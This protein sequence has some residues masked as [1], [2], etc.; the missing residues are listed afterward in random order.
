LKV[1]RRLALIGSATA[2]VF[3]LL[4]ATGAWAAHNLSGTYVRVCVNQPSTSAY[5]GVE[6]ALVGLGSDNP[7]N[8]LVAGRARVSNSLNCHKTGH[9]RALRVQITKVALMDTGRVLA[10]GGPTGSAASVTRDTN[11]IRK[12]CFLAYRV[13]VRFAVRYTDGALA[14]GWANSTFWRFPC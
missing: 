3:A 6:V 9:I 11:G 7:Y 5:D 12:S 4:P 8:A 2:A 1:L 13:G 14:T 10:V